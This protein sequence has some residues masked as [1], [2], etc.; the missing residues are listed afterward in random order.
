MVKGEL[1]RMRARTQLSCACDGVKKSEIIPVDNRILEEDSQDADN[2]WT[3][4]L[5]Q[6]ISVG[7]L[8]NEL[9]R[10]TLL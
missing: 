9:C 1:G 3:L 7:Y 10:K 6:L 5:A 2:S 8:K 4:F